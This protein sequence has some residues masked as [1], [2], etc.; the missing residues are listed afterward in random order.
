MHKNKDFDFVFHFLQI[1]KRNRIP[2][3]EER[4]RPLYLFPKVLLFQSRVVFSAFF[5]HYYCQRLGATRGLGL[6]MRVFSIMHKF[7]KYKTIFKFSQI[8]KSLV[9]AVR[10]RCDTNDKHARNSIPIID[11]NCTKLFRLPI[12]DSNYTK[13]FQLSIVHSD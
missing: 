5:F 6:K 10:W 3:K 1:L 4:K 7:S 8:P 2:Q 11:S 12:V 13:F 9:T